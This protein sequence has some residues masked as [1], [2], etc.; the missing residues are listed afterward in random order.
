MVLLEA[1]AAAQVDLGE[2]AGTGRVRR[3]P[4]EGPALVVDDDDVVGHGQLLGR[5]DG[6]AT[7]GLVPGLDD[8]GRPCRSWCWRGRRCRRSVEVDR[9]TTVVVDEVGGVR[10]VG[11]LGQALDRDRARVVEPVEAA[12]HPG[13]EVIE[14]GRV[15]AGRAGPLD[16]RPGLAVVLQGCA[17]LGAHEVVRAVGG[18]ES[19][20][21]GRVAA[22]DLA[23]RVAH[24]SAARHE[25]E[26]DA[27]DQYH[28]HQRQQ[29]H[30]RSPARLRAGVHGRDLVG[31]G[32]S[33][34][35]GLP[36]AVAQA[37]EAVAHPQHGRADRAAHRLRQGTGQVAVGVAHRGRG[38]CLRR[39]TSAPWPR[40]RGGRP[41]RPRRWPRRGGADAP[42]PPAGAG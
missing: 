32:L 38:A 25:R 15:E 37:V 21:Q 30:G 1:G 23:H 7:A 8:A 17:G 36:E 12:A 9:A 28:G 13:F 27:H 4:A 42:R 35:H 19:G 14:R 3:A 10:V 18:I 20:A 41:S 39:A 24:V 33:V 5:V 22:G 11:Q 40:P 6:L 2:G 31:A 34:R 26:H 16:L 29:A